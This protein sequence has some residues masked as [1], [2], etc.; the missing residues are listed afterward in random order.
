M[1]FVSQNGEFIE[2]LLE[3]NFL[4]FSLNFNEKFEIENSLSQ[5]MS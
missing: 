3:L 2:S 5:M 4:S 1:K